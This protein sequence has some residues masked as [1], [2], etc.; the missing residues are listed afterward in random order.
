MNKQ[1]EQ[2]EQ[3]FEPV[4]KESTGKKSFKYENSNSG[5]SDFDENED[6]NNNNGMT[7]A[8][9]SSVAGAYSADPQMRKPT[10]NRRATVFA[11]LYNDETGEPIKPTRDRKDLKKVELLKIMELKTVGKSRPFEIMSE[12]TDKMMIRFILHFLFVEHNFSIIE[13]FDGTDS[14]FKVLQNQP[15]FDNRRSKTSK[16]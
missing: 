6:I 4:K 1:Q 10:F 11:P 8:K 5:S 3:K 9:Q 12:V 13:L 14:I 15:A 7:Y 16:F 2:E